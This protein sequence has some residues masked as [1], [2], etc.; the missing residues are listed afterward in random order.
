MYLNDVNLPENWSVC[1]IDGHFT[2]NQMDPSSTLDKLL[3]G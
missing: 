2:V 1:F 3:V